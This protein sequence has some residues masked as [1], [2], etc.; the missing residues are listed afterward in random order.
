MNKKSN[1]NVVMNQLTHNLILGTFGRK[2]LLF[3]VLVASTSGL[4]AQFIPPCEEP[5][6]MD[7]FFRCNEAFY[8]PVCACNFKTYRTECT[9]RN[10]HGINTI[11]SDGVCPEDGFDY[12]FYPNPATENINFAIEFPPG[13]QG[14][15]II[16]IFDTYGK[17]MYFSHRVSIHRLDE[18]IMVNAFR[19]GLYVIT[20]MSGTT[21]KAKKLIVK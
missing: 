21:Y 18:L 20:I 4:K 13:I 8:R 2:V 15:F 5:L 9:A 12:D 10:V 19:P 1:V 16:Q 11:N 3:L 14:N 6:R 7:P 17:L